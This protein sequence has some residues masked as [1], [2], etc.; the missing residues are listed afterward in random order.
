MLTTSTVIGNSTSL[1][2][3]AVTVWVPSDLMGS[4]CRFLR[5]MTTLVCSSTACA[6]S[7][8]VTEPTCVQVLQPGYKVGERI[9]RPARVAVAEPT[10]PAGV[11]PASDEAPAEDNDEEI[12]GD[13]AAADDQAAEHNESGN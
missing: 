9:L 4:M 10:D 13:T 8:D 5:S 2:S 3:L 1:W 12:S 7:A 6:T 11:R